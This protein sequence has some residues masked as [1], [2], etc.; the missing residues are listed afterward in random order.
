VEVRQHQSGD[1]LIE[2]GQRP[3]AALVFLRRGQVEVCKRGP[4]GRLLRVARIDEGAA[5]GELAFVDD[6]PASATIRAVTGGLAWV[7]AKERLAGEPLLDKLIRNIAEGTA[8]RLRRT[9]QELVSAMEERLH[10]S[11]LRNDF[12]DFFVTTLLL[13]TLFNLMQ[14]SERFSPL[15]QM[16]YSWGFLLVLLLPIAIFLRSAPDMPLAAFGLTTRG[17]RGATAEGLALAVPLVALLALFKAVQRPDEP[18]V[19]WALMAGYSRR[20]MA[21]YFA[22]YVAHAF[23]QEFIARGVFQGALARFM[24]DRH[25][26]V[27]VGLSSLMFAL[28]HARFSLPAA[29]LSV[30][31]G[32]VLGVI[33]DRQRNLFGVTAVHYAL[34]VAAMALGLL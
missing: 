5:F 4:R 16:L 20:Q 31:L 11:Q 23:I 15:G 13:F 12:G 25:R 32:F 27:P 1:L 14:P 17:W 10:E 9:N 6:E 2:E 8:E 3:P 18:L 29:L 26:L 30:A 7:L 24:A 22:L 21:A 19:T 33:Y 28:S 34:G